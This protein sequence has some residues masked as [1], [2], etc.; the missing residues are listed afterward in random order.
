[1]SNLAANPAAVPY[2]LLQTVLGA[3]LKKTQ[4]HSV[5]Y[6][7]SSGAG[8]EPVRGAAVTAN[9]IGRD[10]DESFAQARVS[11]SVSRLLFGHGFGAISSP[12]GSSLFCFNSLP[13]HA[14]ITC[15]GPRTC[16]ALRVTVSLE[17]LFGKYA[18]KISPEPP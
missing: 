2:V 4:D 12:C 13:H 9:F 8:Y 10:R 7:P 17:I 11:R 1:M 15:W 18:E 14:K 16:V 3:L 6:S 5:C